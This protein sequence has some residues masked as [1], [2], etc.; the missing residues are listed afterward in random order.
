MTRNTHDIINDHFGTAEAEQI[1]SGT[2]TSGYVPIAAGAGVAAAWTALPE[3]GGLLD[4]L[5][6]NDADFTASV[7]SWT[8]SSGAVTRDTTYKIAGTTASLKWAAP[9]SGTDYVECPIAGTFQTGVTYAALVYLSVEDTDTNARTFNVEMGVPGTDSAFNP[10]TLGCVTGYPG[11]A[12]GN[13]LAAV[14]YWVPTADRTTVKL[15]IK[16]TTG[17]VTAT[18]HVGAARAWQTPTVG[19]HKVGT[20]YPVFPAGNGNLQFSPWGIG[21]GLTV[22]ADGRV[23]IENSPSTAG[24]IASRADAHYVYVWAEHTPGDLSYEGIEF[25]VGDDYVALYFSEKAAGVYQLYGYDDQGFELRDLGTGHWFV[26]NPGDTV[27]KNLIEMEQRKAS[28]SATVASGTTSISVT[29]GAGYTPVAADLVVTPT[30]NPTN[31]PGWFWINNVGA[32]TFD[33][34]VRNDPGSGGAT[35]SWRVDR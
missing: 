5:T 23:A 32:T 9:S 29:H 24:V 18:L 4:L 16:D 6:G 19:S 13:F 35:F 12:S 14:V 25:D 21:R 2:P 3:S 8:S 17:S 11:V 26:S 27:S 22:S 34:N 28:G 33:I 31:D 20:L 10:I 15:R 7:G 1:A 30:N